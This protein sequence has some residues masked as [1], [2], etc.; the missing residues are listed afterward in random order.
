VSRPAAEA[1]RRYY[2]E[3]LAHGNVPWDAWVQEIR[4]AREAAA[5]LLNAEPEEV[6][7]LSTSSLGMNYAAQLVGDAGEV[8][9]PADEFPT[10]SLPWLIRGYQLV[11]V[12]SR[13]HGVVA[14]EDLQA[15]AGPGT[16]VVVTS[17][18]QYASGFRQ[19]L[20]RLGAWC[21][22][23]GLVF[24]VDATQGL[25]ALPLDVRASHIDFLVCSVSVRCGG[26]LRG[27]VR[28]RLSQPRGS[29][30]DAPHLPSRVEA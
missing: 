3:A 16:R 29:L 7:F 19:D 14:V 24:V 28:S 12:P 2:D 21:R 8:L 20:A 4:T 6:A 30:I 11:R 18:V 5:R 13:A 23:R 9:L 22:E 10:S 1:G 17:Y 15:A 27:P 25:G 26:V